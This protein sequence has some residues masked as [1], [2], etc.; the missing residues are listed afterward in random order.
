MSK[1]F[2]I[3]TTLLIALIL[4]FSFNFCF[5]TDDNG[6]KNMINDAA[7]GVRNAVGGAENVIEGAVK[8]TTNGIKSTTN[9]MENRANNT[10]NN[11]IAYSANRTATTTTTDTAN[12]MGM[13]A[14]M[15]TWLILGISAIVIIA[16]VW[17]YSNQ[18]SRTDR[19]DDN[20]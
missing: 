16:L 13:S 9:T 5:A 19:Y 14:N 10:I 15:W 6:A 18:V 20:D 4:A 8:D 1:K 12:F 7:N 2:L 11:N 17:Y 3:I